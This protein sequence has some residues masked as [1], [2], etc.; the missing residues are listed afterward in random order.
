MNYMRRQ[1][2][3]EIFSQIGWKRVKK[4]VK[5]IDNWPKMDW[6]I[7]I[8]IWKHEFS[9][10]SLIL[11]NG[12]DIRKYSSQ[13][14][15]DVYE[16][17][18]NWNL[19]AWKSVRTHST[20]DW[21]M[22]IQCGMDWCWFGSKTVTVTIHFKCWFLGTGH[23]CE[24]FGVDDFDVNECIIKQRASMGNCMHCPLCKYSTHCA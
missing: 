18:K 15:S 21:F 10:I 5:E 11:S 19:K 22:K 12:R 23:M 6:L 16:L 24:I 3:I 17:A 20:Q 2:I 7:K 8:K 13:Y 1:K 4:R 9:T 14:I